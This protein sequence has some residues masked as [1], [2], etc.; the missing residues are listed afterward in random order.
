MTDRIPDLRTKRLLIKLQELSIGDAIKLAAMPES[1]VMATQRQFL[2]SVVA[3]AEGVEDIGAWTAQEQM[4][5]VGHYLAAV[6]DVGFVVKNNSGDVVG[7]FSDYLLMEQD[8]TDVIHQAGELAGDTWHVRHLTGDMLEAIER[9]IPEF[10]WL[11]PYAVWLVAMMAAQLV[12]E[13]QDNPAPGD[14]GPDDFDHYLV[15]RMNILLGFTEADFLV[16]SS[17]FFSGKKKLAHFFD[18]SIHNSGGIVALP[19]EGAAPTVPPVRFR[20]HSCLSPDAKGL[21]GKS[22]KFGA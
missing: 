5:V 9:V 10:P 16:L 7:Q 20:V 13:G 11:T 6:S 21:V 18:M 14:G 19:K 3:S 12:V 8:Y 15:E 22:P 2:N 17:F 1:Q 4:L